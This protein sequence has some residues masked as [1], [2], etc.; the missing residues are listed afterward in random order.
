MTRLLLV[1]LT[2]A[3]LAIATPA[4]A[5]LCTGSASFARAPWQLSA[6][7]AFNKHAK[8]LGGGLG[9]GGSGLF[10]QFTAGRTTYDLF[11]ASSFDLG[12]GGGYQFAL[13]RK[14]VLH[15][16]PLASV[17]HGSGPNDVAVGSQLLNLSQNVVAVGLGIGAVAA[18]SSATKIIPSAS[19]A[20][21]ST[22]AKASD[23]SSGQSITSSETLGLLELGVGFLFGEVFSLRPNVAFAFGI[24]QS[25]TTYGAS[26]SVN[27]GRRGSHQTP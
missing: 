21:V 11:D 15:L 12:V 10:V 2:G 18:R 24:D 7:A 13:D 25:S 9:L 4:R 5:Q 22:K 23:R 19:F 17:T 6:A 3:S 27:F 8:S 16:C 20:M 1:S 14:G 26:M